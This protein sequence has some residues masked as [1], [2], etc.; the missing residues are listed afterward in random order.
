MTYTSYFSRYYRLLIILFTA[1][2]ISCST[3]DEGGEVPPVSA[4]DMVPVD[5]SVF[6][7]KNENL[8]QVDILGDP[9]DRE[10]INLSETMGIPYIFQE[11]NIDGPKVTFFTLGGGSWEFWQKDVIT[12]N[13]MRRS[14]ICDPVDGE[15]WRFGKS[16]EDQLALMTVINQG[17]E[18]ENYLRVYDP[19]TDSCS[20]F[21]INDMWLPAPEYAH[22]Y[23]E[24]LYVYSRSEQEAEFSL[25]IY[26][27][28]TGEQ[29]ERL[30]FGTEFRSTMSEE[31]LYL[32][33]P[34]GN[35]RTYSLTDYSPTAEGSTGNRN[36]FRTSGIYPTDFKG[37]KM[38]FDYSYS[39]PAPLSSA[40]AIYDL[41]V[42]E[43]THGGDFY[44]VDAL[45]ELQNQKE[46][47]VVHTT[48]QVDLNSNI[49]IAG[50]KIYDESET[51]G[52]LFLNFDGE[53]LMDIPLDYVP[54]RIMIR[55]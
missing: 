14:P 28:N 43:I 6:A 36:L 19:A 51:G 25:T 37:N 22:L 49:V 18:W 47:V 16:S 35:Y 11:M 7:K 33:F 13:T 12:G 9:E 40:P 27:S 24:R 52:V 54:F 29:V 42:N 48:V 32:F 31:Q 20:R 44:L 46:Q 4:E 55:E 2:F 21:F 50:Y 3:S 15:G 38:A 17:H 39:Q 1:H 10:V 41:S 5:I 53:I 45:R 8:F 23:K 26:N 30:T 34:N